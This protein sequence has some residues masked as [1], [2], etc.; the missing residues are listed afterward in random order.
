MEGTN[1]Y[2]ECLACGKMLLT[3]QERIIGKCITCQLIESIERIEHDK[4][5]KK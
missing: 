1:T 5:G 3:F 2:N 4:K